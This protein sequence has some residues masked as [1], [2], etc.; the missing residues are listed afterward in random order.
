MPTEMARGSGE[1]RNIEFPYAHSNGFMLARREDRSRQA[2]FA[3]IARLAE[4]RDVLQMTQFANCLR[5]CG[6]PPDRFV[7]VC[8]TPLRLP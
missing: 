5:R 6:A 1:W 8:G 3:V 4:R 7:R 2:E